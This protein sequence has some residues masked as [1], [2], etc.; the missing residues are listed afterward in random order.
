MDDDDAN[1]ED[2]AGGVGGSSG[3]EAADKY[4]PG[5]SIDENDISGSDKANEWISMVLT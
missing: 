2:S 5:A 1:D 4:G 3:S